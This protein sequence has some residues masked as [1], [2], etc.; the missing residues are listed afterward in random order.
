[1]RIWATYKLAVRKQKHTGG[2][3][4]DEATLPNEPEDVLLSDDDADDDADGDN[5]DSAKSKRKPSPQSIDEFL[6][7]PLFEKINAVCV[8]SLCSYSSTH[9]PGF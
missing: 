4:G 5:K 7:S 1:M 2:G 3:D 8:S 9:S 6:L